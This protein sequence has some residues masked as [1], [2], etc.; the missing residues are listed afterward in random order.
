MRNSIYQS[1]RN[2]VF[3]NRQDRRVVACFDRE[4]SMH[5]AHLGARAAHLASLPAKLSLAKRVAVKRHATPAVAGTT[6]CGRQR[7][8]QTAITWRLPAPGAGPSGRRG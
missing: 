4:S 2:D 3:G 8:Q 5:A 7:W 6:C 1:N